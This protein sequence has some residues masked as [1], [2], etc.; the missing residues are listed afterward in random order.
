MKVTKMGQE[1]TSDGGKPSG[2]M[3]GVERRQRI[4]EATQAVV[5]E[6]GVQGAT[7]SRIASAAGIS[8]KTLY[9]HFASRREMLVEAM[10]AVF[11]QARKQAFLC[12]EDVDIVDHLR[13]T[14]V[15]HR[16]GE[17]AFVYPLFEFFAAPPAAGL[18][19]ELKA[20]HETS[21]QML[22]DLI[23]EG[24]AQGVIRADVNPEQT[25]WDLM[26][27]YWADDVAYLLGFEVSERTAVM[28]ERI[29]REIS[30]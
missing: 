23:E 5:A 11:D 20:R 2:R 14:T 22:T 16:L 3:T 15:S 17:G 21:I 28:A 19:E 12:R 18:R 30:I 1:E 27:V 7:T 4:I 13:K 26:S 24:K 6:C 10:D 25:A 29:F 9:A 8:E